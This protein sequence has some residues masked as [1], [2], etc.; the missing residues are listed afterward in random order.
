MKQNLL[1]VLLLS[2]MTV[3]LVACGG[4]TSSTPTDE[5]STPSTPS[6]E[7]STPVE[8]SSTPEEVE[9]ENPPVIELSRRIFIEGEDVKPYVTRF[10]M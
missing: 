1:K 4:E 3:S 10:D 9:D 5:P 2:M 8:E 6:V 7:S